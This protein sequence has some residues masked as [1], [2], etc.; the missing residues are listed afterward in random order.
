MITLGGEYAQ[1]IKVELVWMEL[2]P[3][4]RESREFP[5]HYHEVKTQQEGYKPGRGSSP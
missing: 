2:V 1:G 3:Y 5:R 4:K